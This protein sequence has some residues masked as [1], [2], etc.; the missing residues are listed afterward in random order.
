MR[1]LPLYTAKD[2]CIVNERHALASHATL[3][4]CHVRLCTSNTSRE[5]RSL[6]WPRTQSEIWLRWHVNGSFEMRMNYG[7][8][9]EKKKCTW[10]FNV[11]HVAIY[12]R[13]FYILLY[14]NQF[15]SFKNIR[16]KQQGKVLLS[17]FLSLFY[18]LPHCYQFTN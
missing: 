13:S 4:P 16:I 18:I 2:S 17:S 5:S 9:I 10:F 1:A 7:W 12:C 15:S 14:R 3:R 11:L 8:I 6:V